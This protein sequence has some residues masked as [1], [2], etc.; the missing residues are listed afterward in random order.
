M[1]D[2]FTTMQV[3]A[4]TGATYR[5][6]DYWSRTGL[7]VPSIA[8]AGGSGT[9]RLYSADDLW[10]VA[11]CKALL[12]GGMS[13][14]AVREVL[15]VACVHGAAMLT[16]KVAIHLDVDRLRAKVAIDPPPGLQLVRS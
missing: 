1:A 6:V 15:D 16:D 11:V 9:Q 10:R 12:D 13:L 3:V 7:C 8:E 2:V 5:Q 14:T 4:R